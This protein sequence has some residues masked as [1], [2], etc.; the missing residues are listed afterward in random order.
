MKMT[1]KYKQAVHTFLED[2]IWPHVFYKKHTCKEVSP[3]LHA[4]RVAG[5]FTNLPS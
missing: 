3:G 5:S 2:S 1:K 4:P